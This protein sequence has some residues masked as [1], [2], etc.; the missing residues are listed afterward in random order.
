MEPERFKEMKIPFF[1]YSSAF[2]Q[3]EEDFVQIFKDVLGKG[4]FIQQAELE[5]FERNLAKYLGVK[6]AFGVGNA[7]DGLTMI[8]RSIGLRPGDEV[9]FPSH[10][11]VATA[12]AIVHAGGIPIPVDC[13]DDHL[14]DCNAIE[15]AITSRT[16]GICPVQ[17]NGRTANMDQI[18]KI[19]EKHD[20]VLVEDAA[21][22]LG[23]KFQGQFAGTFGVAS[24]F[25]FYPA[26]L[27]GC[28]GDG[29]AVVTDDDQT[30]EQI[31]L[32]RDHGRSASNGEVV[33]WGYNSRLDNLQ[34]AFL[35]RQLADYSSY[36]ELRRSIAKTYCDGLS[37]LSEI[38]LPPKPDSTSLHFDV[39]QNFEIEA[40]QR[41]ELQRFLELNGIGTIRQWGG[42]AVHQ[43]PALG[44]SG[45]CPRT[46]QLF[47]RCLMLPLNIMVTEE[48]AN[49]VVAT[50]RD[51][52]G[53]T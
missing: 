21:Q 53:A 32:L 14:I 33:T 28:L 23:S 27:L 1:N 8:W 10:T 17:L 52:Y 5:D 51:F 38:L 13:G 34:A 50:I 29:G 42:K 39:Y 20:L 22:A 49:C 4:A 3:L 43:N 16:R 7:T 31:L 9:I 11:M 41:D 48:Q 30:A 18:L 36:V 47:E 44:L 46:E 12:A 37:D 6:Y 35:N 15:E 40:E 25:S 45:S 24:A 19:C 2:Q 26:K